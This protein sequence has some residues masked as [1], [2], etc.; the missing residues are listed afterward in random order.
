MLAASTAQV[1]ALGL[2]PWHT[3]QSGPPTIKGTWLDGWPDTNPV[4]IFTLP[5]WHVRQVVTVI[6]V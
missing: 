5:L 2:L 3:P 4:D 6:C 1:S